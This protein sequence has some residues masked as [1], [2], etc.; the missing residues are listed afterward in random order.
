MHNV[1]PVPTHDIWLFPVC[2]L[3][4]WTPF[5]QRL[6]RQQL[7][8][9][10]TSLK[11]LY[12][13]LLKSRQVFTAVRGVCFWE[14]MSVAGT[15]V[16]FNC[17]NLRIISL[18]HLGCYSWTFWCFFFCFFSLGC[19]TDCFY[20]AL[21]VLISSSPSS[22]SEGPRSHPFLNS[23]HNFPPAKIFKWL[24]SLIPWWAVTLNQSS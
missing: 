23:T 18:R 4:G 19:E 7:L 1:V 20:H 21:L 10:K 9:N 15:T 6:T 14:L 8:C 12:V 24:K 3:G 2:S 13:V 22:L 16:W 11:S 5:F 17:F